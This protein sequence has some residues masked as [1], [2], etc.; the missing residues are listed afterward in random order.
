MATTSHSEQGVGGDNDESKDTKA[1]A[2][3]PKDKKEK[4]AKVRVLKCN[5][6]VA[7]VWL[8]VIWYTVSVV[9]WPA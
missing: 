7:E 3:K 6:A 5:I 1:A 9:L 4:M 2:K 8:L